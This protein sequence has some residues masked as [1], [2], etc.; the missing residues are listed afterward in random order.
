M[1]RKRTDGW[2]VTDGD[3]GWRNMLARVESAL[4]EGGFEFKGIR[5]GFPSPRVR[6]VNNT[7]HTEV[8]I[9]WGRPDG[10]RGNPNFRAALGFPEMWRFAHVGNWQIPGSVTGST[11][12]VHWA[13]NSYVAA[14]EPSSFILVLST[15]CDGAWPTTLPGTPA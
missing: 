12:V 13:P 9:Q 15:W 6:R 14:W 10:V 8:G 5:P 11:G 1:W 7:L 2:T 3:T 4:A